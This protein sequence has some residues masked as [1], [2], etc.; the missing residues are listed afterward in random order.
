MIETFTCN[1]GTR[2]SNFTLNELKDLRIGDTKQMDKGCGPAIDGPSAGDCQDWLRQKGFGWPENDE[3]EWGGTGDN[4]NLCSFEYGC[5]CNTW[6][7]NVTGKRGKVKRKS[8]KGDPSECCLANMERKDGN[9][10][11]GNFTCDPKYRD[12]NSTDCTNIYADYCKQGDR[13]MTD[14]KC[15]YL[16]QSNSTLYNSLMKEKCNTDQY[17]QHSTC[18]NWCA[19]NSTECSKLNTFQDCK[20]LGISIG[21]CTPQKI[22]DVKAD[23][24]KYGIRSQQGLAIYQCSPAGID[25]LLAEC[26]TNNVMDTCSPTSIQD[27]IDNATRRA[28]LDMQAKTQE[29]IQQ[30]YDT[31]QKTIADILNVTGETPKT[32]IPETTSQ[33][34]ISNIKKL[35]TDNYVIAIIIAIILIVISSSSSASLL[36]VVLKK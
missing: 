24:E 30:N 32:E 20:K 25:A 36:F 23:C 13:M 11:V 2:P 33:F 9:K 16:A 31:T 10:T 35:V 18:I 14:T 21:E 6:G 34:D 27:A 7:Q 28:Q 29:Q 22:L 5:E 26:R 4:C 1:N 17:Y 8:F 15:Q 3:F 19:N 12:P